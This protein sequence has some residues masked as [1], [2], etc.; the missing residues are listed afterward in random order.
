[1]NLS[2]S[3]CWNS[4]RHIKGDA[5]LQEISDLGFN[6][7]ELGHGIRLSLWEG[8]EQFVADHPMKIT[9]LHNFCPLPIEILYAAPD[10]YQCTSDQPDERQRAQRHT[11]QTIDQ[12]SKLGVGKVV[13]HLG[14][15]AMPN[16]TQRLID[17]IQSGKYLDRRYVDIKLQA[18]AKRESVSYWE[19][20]TNWLQPVIEHA[21]NAQV[22]L[23]IENRIGIETFPSEKEF[24]QL[25]T[26]F[27]DGSVGYWHDFGHAQVRHNLTFV[28]HKEWLTQYAPLLIGCHL[29]DVRFPARDHQVPFNGMI[30]FTDLIPLVPSHVPLVW[31]LSPRAARD[32]ITRALMRWTEEFGRG[33]GSGKQE[34]GTN[35]SSF[36]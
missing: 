5:M 31:E 17:R 12:A 20:V 1:V 35:S 13:M 7:V 24:H 14:S 6:Q 19:R 15:V 26:E 29:H 27:G 11:L 25:F 33:F 22:V 9:S 28:D 2:F 4:D 3:T 8:I 23:G 34:L 18:I 16:Y 30:N 32:E 10:C 36:R 21:R